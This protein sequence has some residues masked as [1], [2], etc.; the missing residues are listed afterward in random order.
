MQLLI[1]VPLM[2]V[3]FKE[4][5]QQRIKIRDYGSALYKNKVVLKS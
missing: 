3:R 1:L 2:Q 4:A 5:V